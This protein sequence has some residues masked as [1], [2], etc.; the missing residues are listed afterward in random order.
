MPWPETGR[1]VAVS[2]T[3]HELDCPLSRNQEERI[4]TNYYSV[5][6]Y[7]A[8]VGYLEWQPRSRKLSRWLATWRMRRRCPA[9]TP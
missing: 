5:G 4:A 3:R 6:R 9:P 7:E 1:K 8:S 2:S